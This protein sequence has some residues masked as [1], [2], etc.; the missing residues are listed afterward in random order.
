[1]QFLPRKREKNGWDEL[2]GPRPH[3]S[4]IIW[5]PNDDGLSRTIISVY[6]EDLKLITRYYLE[7]TEDL[8]EYYAEVVKIS[9]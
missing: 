8:G 6:G 1:M 4:E 3:G 2:A 7:I 5:R 9:K